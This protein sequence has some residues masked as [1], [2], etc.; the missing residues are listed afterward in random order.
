MRGEFVHLGSQSPHS[1][2]NS[3]VNLFTKIGCCSREQVKSR[4]NRQLQFV[5]SY[6]EED[7]IDKIDKEEM[8]EAKEFQVLDQSLENPVV[9][10]D[11]KE[12]G[13]ARN[14]IFLGHQ[15]DIGECPEWALC[16]RSRI[17]AQGNLQTF[18]RITK[19]QQNQHAAPQQPPQPSFLE[20]YYNG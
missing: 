14:A 16:F 7:K 8:N 15:Q 5:Q 1:T 13:N 4:L 18:T 20:Q 6:R 2:G 3:C 19:N 10:E 11:E 9:F 12:A 17:K